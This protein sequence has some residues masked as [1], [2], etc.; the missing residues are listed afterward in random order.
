MKKEKNIETITTFIGADTQIEGTIEF[1]KSLRIDGMVKGAIKSDHG[2]VIVGKNGNIEADISVA[3][4]II[5]GTITG[6][7]DATQRIELHSPAKI[8]GNITSACIAID[9]GVKLDGLCATQEQQ[10]TSLQ[11]KE[12]QKQAIIE[13]NRKE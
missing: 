4:A 6:T 13:E 12:S 11:D 3:T 9:T 8:K 2:T 1:E 5:M 7:I 10:H